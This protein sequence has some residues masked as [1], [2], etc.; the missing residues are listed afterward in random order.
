MI[1]NINNNLYSQSSNIKRVDNIAK[2]EG[3][4]NIDGTNNRVA[5]I[6]KEIEENKYQLVAPHILARVFAENELGL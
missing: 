3:V 4:Q 2:V 6:K 1:S 5:E